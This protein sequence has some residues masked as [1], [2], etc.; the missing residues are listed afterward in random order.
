MSETP[1]AYFGGKGRLARTIADLFPE[2]ETYV[3]P[4]AGSL[5][6]LLA[7][8]RSRIEIVNDLDRDLVT[9]WRVVRDHP[10]EF[11]RLLALTPHARTEYEHALTDPPTDTTDLERARRLWVRVM[12]GRGAGNTNVGW[13]WRTAGSPLSFDSNIAR[14]GTVGQRLRNVT[15]ENRD[16][17]AV[18]RRHTDNPNALLYLDPPYVQSTRSGNYRHEYTDAQHAALADAVADAAATVVISGYESHDYTD[19][20]RQWEITRLRSFST[21]G[22]AEGGATER[23]EILW[24]NRPLGVATLPLFEIEET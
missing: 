18:I 20:F 12:Q 2:H 23:I 6:V 14:M 4:F 7:K 3:E 13:R 10:H 11:A 21:V 22:F 17:L 9:F 24:S 15:I 8:R 16:A 19:H 1:L 5:A